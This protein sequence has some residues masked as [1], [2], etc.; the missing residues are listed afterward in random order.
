MRMPWPACARACSGFLVAGVTDWS[1]RSTPGQYATMR[2]DDDPFQYQVVLSP[3]VAERVEREAGTRSASGSVGGTD[4]IR[5]AVAEYLDRLDQQS[6]DSE[7][8]LKRDAVLFDY[9]FSGDETQPFQRLS[10]GVIAIIDQSGRL[11]DEAKL[12][13]DA[14]HHER[15]EF[16]IAAA[17]EEMGKAYLLID[18]CRVD[19]AQRRDVLRRLCRDFY[20]FAVKHVYFDLSVHDYPGIGSLEEV[21]DRF[22]LGVKEGWPVPP[23]IGEPDMGHETHS[24]REANL[25]VDV[26]AYAGCWLVPHFP[27]K[28]MNPLDDTWLALGQLRATQAL[29]LFQPKAL[30][31]LNRQMKS[32]S[33]TRGTSMAQLTESYRRAGSDIEANAGVSLSAFNMSELS[34]W[35][36][37]WIER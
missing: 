34:G 17:Q 26:D 11:L 35:P 6:V 4:I 21:E 2:N 5:E 10:A 37:Y 30:Q 1:V 14:K 25:H 15:G 12:L 9:L 28:A 22:R 16:L 23:E 27:A 32:L 31:I 7:R 19:L 29:G 36:M 3:Q 8:C 24:L 20:N 13:A 33:I 18:M